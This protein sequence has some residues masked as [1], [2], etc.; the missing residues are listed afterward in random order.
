MLS[1]NS[2]NLV[3]LIGKI[4]IFV[5]TT[6]KNISSNSS[7]KFNKSERE[8]YKFQMKNLSFNDWKQKPIVSSWGIQLIHE[9]Q[10]SRVVGQDLAGAC[11]T[12]MCPC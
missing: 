1:F 5:P 4:T 7:M 3:Q 8:I 2:W 9:S 12:P 6:D 10:G 11:P